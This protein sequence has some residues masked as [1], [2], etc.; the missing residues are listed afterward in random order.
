MYPFIHIGHFSIGTF[1]ILLWLAAVCAC[2]VLYRNFLRSGIQADAIGIVAIVT[3]VG[4]IGAKLWHVADT[5]HEHIFEREGF[6]WYG[7]L[8]FGILALLWQGWATKIGAVRMLDLAAPA[9]AV[10][11]GMGRL[12]C[13]ISGDGDYGIPTKLPWGMSFPNGLVPTT[14]RVHPT[15]IYELLAGLAIGYYLWRR[16]ASQKPVGEITGEYL[17][18]S[19]V[20]RFLVEFIRINP[21]IYWGMSNAQVASLGAVAVGVVFV[22]V[23]RRHGVKNLAAVDTPIVEAKV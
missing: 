22:I 15:P 18:L 10:G 23:A 17:I 1:G 2:W 3:V 5:P 7:G 16:G 12:G 11:Y 9:A 6:A 13:L 21:K 8:I 14:D 4:I 19:G 20:A